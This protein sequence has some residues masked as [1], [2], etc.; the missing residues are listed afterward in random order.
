MDQAR[1]SV[2]E[3]TEDGHAGYVQRDVN[4]DEA[5][6]SFAS[7]IGTKNDSRRRVIILVGDHIHVEWTPQTGMNCARK[8]VI[9]G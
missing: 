1:F 5:V 7:C 4:V 8:P 3:F 2:V 9:T 6:N